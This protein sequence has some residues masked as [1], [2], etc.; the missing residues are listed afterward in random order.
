MPTI[1]SVNKPKLLELSGGK[2]EKIGD[3]DKFSHTQKKYPDYLVE[4]FQMVEDAISKVLSQYNGK[5]IAFLSD[6]GVSYMAQFGTGLNLAGVETNHAG[7]CGSWLKGMASVDN[8]YVKMEDGKT[9]CSLTH[10]SLSA[11]TPLGQGAHG[12]ATP[13]E[14]LVPI[15]IVSNQKNANVYSANLLS[16]EIVA[17]APVVRYVIKGMSTVDTPVVLYNGVEYNLYKVG[18]DT[19]ESERLNLVSTSTRIT[20]RIGDFSHTDNLSINMGA[21]EDDLFDF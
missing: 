1:T 11:K 21:Q 6:H 13:E 10:N 18:D 15:I 2:L 3:I 20:L 19:Y 4:E 12:G 14:I 7:R 8:N 5:K 17:S 9:L 16:S